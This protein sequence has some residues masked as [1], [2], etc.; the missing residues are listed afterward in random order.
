VGE[1]IIEDCVSLYVIHLAQ[2]VLL[3]SGGPL[4]T[5]EIVEKLS[6]KIIISPEYLRRHLRDSDIFVFHRRRWELRWR[7]EAREASLE[8]IVSSLLSSLGYPVSIHEICKWLSEA[9]KGEVSVLTDRLLGLLKSRTG[10]FWEISEGKFGLRSWLIDTSSADEN[11]VI[12]DS[13][14]G[15]EEE[16]NDL[17]RRV[18]ELAIDFSLPLSDVCQRLIDG[19]SKPLSHSEI[20]LI[21]WR[22]LNYKP[23]AEEVL[24]ELFNAPNL[25]VLSPGY[26]CTD[27]LIEKMHHLVEEGALKER[28]ILARKFADID[29][30]LKRAESL[31][32]RQKAPSPIPI[33]SED[34]DDMLDWLKGRGAPARID[35]ILFEAFELDHRDR[36]YLPT[37]YELENRLSKDARLVNLGNHMWWFKEALPKHIGSIPDELLPKTLKVEG[38]LERGTFDVELPDEALEPD[39]VRWVNEPEYEDVGEPVKLQIAPKE[40]RSTIIPI[41]YHHIVAGTMK[42]REVDKP[43][44]GDEAKLQYYIATDEHGFE[45]PVWVNMETG[46]MFGFKE[47]YEQR[48]IG[49][50]AL[51]KLEVV[52]GAG[53]LKLAWNKKYDRYLHLPSGRVNQLLSY[54]RQEAVARATVVELMQSII[55][56]FYEDGVHFLRLWAEVNFLRRTSK[57]LIASILSLYACFIRHPQK[58]G[59]W[60]YE[61]ERSAE[62]IRR[63]KRRLVERLIR[64]AG[65]EGKN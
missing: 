62:G 28:E 34:W 30:V 1:E 27:M 56:P 37:L 12:A 23:T 2:H 44:F 65:A 22:G 13:F 42:L 31:L 41:P 3:N 20:T 43:M 9:G 7:Y 61:Y 47:W 54:A 15:R 19:L 6:D 48:G 57:R 58:E 45:F 29:K 5:H 16:I 26:W 8:G 14:F 10:T 36:A 17:L 25:H 63:E 46:L 24:R 4:H 50:G 18:D 39:L 32:S 60:L 64:Q 55:M 53:K 51:I 35:V 38:A 52:R 49:A 11:S 33:T 21:C 59:Y 40:K